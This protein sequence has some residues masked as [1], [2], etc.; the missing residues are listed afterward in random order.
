MSKPQVEKEED[1]H[2]R[3]TSKLPTKKFG[4]ESTIFLYLGSASRISLHRQRVS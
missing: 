4:S 3:S 2:W 1:E